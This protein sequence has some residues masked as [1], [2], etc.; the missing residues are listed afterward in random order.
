MGDPTSDLIKDLKTIAVLG[1]AAGVSYATASCAG[2]GDGIDQ[3]ISLA[4][5][6]ALTN[7]M[8]NIGQMRRIG[9]NM[10]NAVSNGNRLYNAYRNVSNGGDKIFSDVANRLSSF[11]NQ[12]A[13]R[14]DVDTLRNFVDLSLSGKYSQN[15]L[16]AIAKQGLKTMRQR[17]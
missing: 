1:V 2:V 14:R 3:V 10:I 13:P 11:I 5:V 17:Q 15:E 12:P 7:Y 6:G 9:S 8:H 4:V 16:S